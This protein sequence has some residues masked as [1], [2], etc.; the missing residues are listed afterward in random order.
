M[1]RIP[2]VV[3]WVV[4]IPVSIALIVW[5]AWI[6]LTAFAGGQAPWFFINFTGFNPFR[7]LLWLVVV[8][9]IVLTVAYWIF[10]LVMLPVVALGAVF[11]KA[12]DS[13]DG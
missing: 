4:G 1:D 5:T 9:P 7:G 8:E 3:Q 12:T 11:S 10:L 13:G 2:C 6:T